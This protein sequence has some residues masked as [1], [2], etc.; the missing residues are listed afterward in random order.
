MFR[1]RFSLSRVEEEQCQEVYVPFPKTRKYV[2]NACAPLIRKLER[3]VFIFSEKLI[4]LPRLSLR[5][6]LVISFVTF[7]TVN[8]ENC[9][10]I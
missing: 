10:L 5:I 8:A 2:D 7:S 9:E 6:I 1:P 4:S 3:T